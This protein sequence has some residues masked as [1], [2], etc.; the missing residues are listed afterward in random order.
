[1][2]D[3]TR[4]REEALAAATDD[5]RQHARVPGPFDGR[6][7]GAIDTPVRIYDLSEG[8]CFIN[9]LHD[10]LLGSAVVLEIDL[11][12][13]GWIRVKGETLYLKPEFGFAVGFVEMT[14]EVSM[15]L[16]RALRKI[17]GCYQTL[18]GGQP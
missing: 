17:R 16:T 18:K 15:R 8:G 4:S 12:Y 6:R 14:D 10:Q 13:E 5:R 9:S 1:M 2:K 3:V 11:P 7:V